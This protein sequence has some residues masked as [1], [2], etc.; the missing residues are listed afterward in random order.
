MKMYSLFAAMALCT[1]SAVAQGQLSSGIDK[2]NMDLTADPGKDFFQY[3]AGGWMKSHPLTAE[4][5]RFAQ[6]DALQEVNREQIKVLVEELAQGKHAQ[7]TLEQKIG[8][9]YRLAMDEK[10]LNDEGF[11]PIRPLLEKIGAV[12]T[13]KE[14]QYCM[15][16]LKRKGIGS[17][18][19][20]YCGADMKNSKMNLMQD[21]QG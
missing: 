9:L 5:S 12:K 18:F 1:G 19:S 16:E 20:V 17:F 10:R 4:Y 7:G 2:A 15:A 13:Q 8:G 11:A 14:F 21:S 3:A 6:F